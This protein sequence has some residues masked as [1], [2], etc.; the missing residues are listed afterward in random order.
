MKLFRFMPGFATVARVLIVALTLGAVVEI[1]PVHAVP[2]SGCAVASDCLASSGDDPRERDDASP[3]IVVAA[4]ESA[5]GIADAE[6]VP[7]A[8]VEP[9]VPLAV[10]P[11]GEARELRDVR[12]PQTLPD[13][14]GPPRA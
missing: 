2:P 14:T 3:A 7:S 11:F 6:A 9:L 10:S 13:K 5:Q 4:I 1:L 12:G 8:F